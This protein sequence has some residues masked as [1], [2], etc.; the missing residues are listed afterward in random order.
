M[1]SLWGHTQ[2]LLFPSGTP[3]VQSIYVLVNFTYSCYIQKIE[4]G[5][6]TWMLTHGRAGSPSFAR[7]DLSQ[8]PP[9]V[10]YCSSRV[11]THLNLRLSRALTGGGGTC[12]FSLLDAPIVGSIFT[13]VN[14]LKVNHLIRHNCS[15]NNVDN[16]LC[17]CKNLANN[18]ME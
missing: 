9:Y 10:P 8:C 15:C 17:H 2:L 12:A 11:T 7:G 18:N 5:Y 14:V 16:I 3:G 1:H 4:F 6:R 13:G